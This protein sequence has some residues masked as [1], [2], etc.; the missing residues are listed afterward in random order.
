MY[1]MNR[2]FMNTFIYSSAGNSYVSSHNTWNTI[3]CNQNVL[4]LHDADGLTAAEKDTVLQWHRALYDKLI[5][6]FIP[7]WTYYRD[8]DGGWNWGAAYAM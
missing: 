6:Q 5:Y 3:F 1:V 2:E 7:C 4:A 8:D